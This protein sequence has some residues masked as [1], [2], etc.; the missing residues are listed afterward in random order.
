MEVRLCVTRQVG[1]QPRTRGSR[2]RHVPIAQ[3]AVGHRDRLCAPL[4]LGW[5]ALAQLTNAVGSLF[6]RT[7]RFLAQMCRAILTLVLN[8]EWVD[9]C[10]CPRRG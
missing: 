2:P 1:L 7:Q 3:V 9:A 8:G 6:L 4:L 5:R 10:V